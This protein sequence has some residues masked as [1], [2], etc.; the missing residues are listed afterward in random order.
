MNESIWHKIEK[1]FASVKFA[2]LIILLFALALTIGTFQE[3]WHGTEYANRLIYK[4]LPFMLLQGCMFL[5]IYFATVLRF[6]MRKRLYGFYVLHLG[7]ILIF[8]GSF[9]TYFAGID[10]NITL[11]PNTPSRIIKINNDTVFIN[12]PAQNQQATYTLPKSA[13]KTSINET[14]RDVTILDYLPFSDQ[15]V[16][17]VTT[18]S[19]QYSSSE[20]LITSAMFNQKFTLSLSREADFPST[21]KMGPLNVHYLVREMAP[22]FGANNKSAILIWNMSEKKCYLPEDHKMSSKTTS[23]GKKFVVA[24]IEGNLLKF[25][26][27]MSPMPLNDKLEVDEDSPYR[28]FSKKLFESSP[29]LFLFGDAVAFFNKDEQKWSWHEMKP[30]DSEAIDLPW[31]GSQ[32]KL[33]KNS[34]EL[35][36]KK[37]PT[38]KTPVQEDGSL[39]VG[40][41]KAI[42][43][44][45]GEEEFWVTDVEPLAVMMQ[46]NKIEVRLG[47]EEITLPYQLNLT[48]FKMDTDPGTNNPASYESFVSL[49]DGQESKDFHIYMNNPLKYDSFTFYQASYFKTSQG[50]GSVLSVNYDPGRWLKYLG[51]FLLVFGSFWHFM[52]NRKKYLRPKQA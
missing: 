46:G 13:S 15:E 37:I 33:L 11:A 50:H 48:N 4:S 51:S 42:K 35:A 21:T 20:Y 18:K 26:P 34:F 5:S 25:F 30:N 36:P 41:D 40:K 39:I 52:I 49:F 6:P 32:L 10:G 14:Y 12:Y 19:K 44:K 28:V 17:W 1:S 3:S 22:C 8:I 29:H 9:V 7:L 47:Q 27:E 45:I 2:V 43:V 31:M 38:A 23:S 16:D 24:T